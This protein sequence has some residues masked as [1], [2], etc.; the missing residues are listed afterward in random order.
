MITFYHLIEIAE[1]VQ[2]KEMSVGGILRW[3]H[4]R[5][6]HLHLSA[7]YILYFHSTQASHHTASSVESSKHI[8]LKSLIIPVP[9]CVY[10][11]NDIF[12]SQL[13]A[14]NW[15]DI[16]QRQ[17]IS[18]QKWQNALFFSISLF[19]CFFIS[20]EWNQCGFCVWHNWHKHTQ[21]WQIIYDW[22][23]FHFQVL[24]NIFKMNWI[25]CI[26]MFPNWNE[27]E[28]M[29]VTNLSGNI[30]ASISKWQENRRKTRRQCLTEIN[31]LGKLE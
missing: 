9:K 11:I 7:I 27:E 17:T 6:S 28:K 29:K 5:N 3:K 14:A 22:Q 18:I 21:W 19:I 23:S 30:Y 26:S 24:A 4:F 15:I 13:K 8:A 10:E 1:R 20:T 16:E 2:Q 31:K 12:E 25:D